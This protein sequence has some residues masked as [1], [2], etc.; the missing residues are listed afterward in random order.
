MTSEDR[1]ITAASPVQGAA[2]LCEQPANRQVWQRPTVTF[3]PM[4]VTAGAKSGGLTD[5]PSNT[6]ASA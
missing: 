1:I 4:Q 2:V 3:V 6:A 5:G